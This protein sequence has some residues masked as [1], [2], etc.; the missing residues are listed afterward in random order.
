[1]RRVLSLLVLLVFASITARAAEKPPVYLWLEPEWFDGVKGN[2]GY[3]TGEAKPTGA[4]GIAGPGISA[5]W[6]QGGESEW[7]SMG[8]PATETK[9]TCGRE[10]VIPRAGK[11]RVWVRFVDHRKKT[12]PFTVKI[13]QAGKAGASAE[14]GTRPVV[15]ENDEYQLYWGFS[16]G[17]GSFEGELAEGKARIDVA[18]DKA[19]E[20]WR[21]VD[22]ILITDD[23]KHTPVGREKPP[24]AYLAAFDLQPKDGAAWRGKG[25]PEAKFARPLVGGRDFAMW[26]A[27]DFDAKKW[28]DVKPDDSKYDLFFRFSPPQDIRDKFHKEFAGKKDLPILSSPM[29]VPGFYL[30]TTP[31]LSPGSPLRAW[32]EKSKQPFY[33]MTNYASGSY[34]DKNGPLTYQ[35]LTGPLAE[36]FMGYVHGEAYG[37]GGVGHSGVATGPNRRDHLDAFG[38]LMVKQQAEQW[39]K[40]YKTPVPETHW[41]KGVS[42]LSVDSIALAHLYQHT[43]AKVVGYELDATNIHTPMR[44]AFERGAA[45]QYGGAWINYA[46]GNFGDAC[47]Y[48]T[49]NPV[50]PRGAPSWF[51]SKYAVTDGVS[52]GWYR[53]M[54]YLNH[55]GG[56]SAIFWEQG[57]GNQWMIPGPGK[58]PIQ[59]SPFGR[60]T[61]DFLAFAERL[62]DRGEPIASVGILLSHGHG[63]ERVNNACKMLN[64]FPENDSDR[65]LRELF[66]VCWHPVGVAEGQPAAP[67]VQSMPNGRYGNIFDVLVDRPEKAVAL[68]NYPVIWAAGDVNLEG[69]MAK[70]LEDY[71]QAGGTLVVNIEAAK[72]LPPKMLGFKPTGKRVRAEE[73]TPTG[74]AVQAATPFEAA[75]I[76]PIGV[77]PLAKTGQHMLVTSHPLGKGKVITVLVPRGLGLDERAHPVLPYLMNG[78]TTDLLPVSV[79]MPD[80]KRP[81]GEIQYQVN[82][83][84]DGF[85]VM[86]MNNRG[87]DK[88]QHGVARV[89]RRQ[90]VDVVIST[91]LPLKSAKEWT[92][93]RDLALT[94]GAN[95][96]IAVRVH[97]GDV[98][99]IGLV[100]K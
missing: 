11:Y 53:K 7:N 100:T 98:Q 45:R 24:F 12:E 89:D 67:D 40:I 66:N 42:C 29:L 95:E 14:L 91:K 90:F 93:P 63:Y 18:I 27:M 54:Y 74:G 21:Q 26:T 72:N 88:T 75:E 32:L 50:V 79:E 92:G 16:F 71:V 70:P 68:A 4:W 59:L 99:V 64:V 3:W 96:K 83:T 23:L 60:A 34:T 37:T 82:R 97:P 15:P 51:H 25:V 36:Q 10:L 73:W 31:D 55:L 46:S 20:A 44:I 35:A 39:T 30:G 77:L 58:H 62:P 61:E 9:A 49:Q 19:G 43:G 78:L 94:G 17:W 86:L 80:G 52:V 56:A 65:E 33:I 69:A 84:K 38:K 41:S 1:M 22:A 5:E 6:T 28:A 87:V 8:A 48:F 85:V 2:F 13:T 76:E 47:N 81:A 57:L